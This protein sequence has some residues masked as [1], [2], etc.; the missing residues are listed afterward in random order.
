MNLRSAAR[1]STPSNFDFNTITGMR[2][3]LAQMIDAPIPEDH[4]AKK[5]K[6][7]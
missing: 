7:K 4:Q 6:K 5:A 2:I 3:E 1:S